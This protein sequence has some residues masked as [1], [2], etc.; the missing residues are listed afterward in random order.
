[1]L[2]LPAILIVS[3]VI[4]IFAYRTYGKFI[5]NKLSI[6]DANI[7]PAH[8]Q[9]DGVDYVPSKPAMVLG[10]H[11]A[12]IAGAGPIVGPIIAITFGWIPA[13]IWILIG[14]IFF[15]AVH[16]I[17]SMVA[18]L[19]HQGKSIGTIIYKYIGENG[20]ILFLL[21]SFSTL[22]LI[23][24][25][26][27]DI[28]AKTFV[29]DP[30]AATASILFL[31]LA[32]V[33][34]IVN[35]QF[36]SKKAFLVLTV[37]GVAVMY[38]MIYIAG[39]IP[40]N[41]SYTVWIGLL[42]AYAFVASVTPVSLILQ[43]RDYLNSYL[44]YGLM[45]FGVVGIFVANPDIVMS[46]EIHYKSDTMGYLFPVLFVTVACGAIS[47]FHSLVASGTTSKQ[48]DR[49]SDA[50]TVGYGGM[51]IE[52]FLAII[53]VCAIIILDRGD[54]I[55]QLASLGPVTLYS[56][57]LGGMISS[58]GIPET[59]AISFVALTVSAFALTTLD[60]CTRL[61]RF[62]MQEL[63][64]GNLI[65]GSQVVTNNRFLSTLIPIGLAILLL[66][67]GEFT[68]LW[69]I[70]GSAN[71]LLAAIAL[72]AITA[73]LH[74]IGVKPFFTFI[75]MAF[76]FVVTLSSLFIFSYNNFLANKYLLSVIAIIL[77]ILAITLLYLTRK[78]LA[79]MLRGIRA[80]S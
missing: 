54:Y 32:I 40:T 24:A 63:T 55:G 53:S 45:L 77:T 37:V 18:S 27:A 75:P 3:A 11:F 38:G 56:Q 25:V 59:M 2:S 69:P 42:L 14:G 8:Q 34:G 51:L 48:L 43:P 16:D 67:S 39:M 30:G 10:H 66:L 46:T 26:F 21:F 74:S 71:Q 58:L 20:K 50:K 70:F 64:E 60:T 19:R 49:E 44:L 41:L 65:P 33:F 68:V 5:A 23:I 31:A 80:S 28:V 79:N 61:A 22:I 29:S 78:I 9:K 62:A 35:K 52:S 36:Q 12:S 1:M 76:M 6:D 72:L 73:W 7:T 13:I 47:G 4:L 57:G 17:G 15:G